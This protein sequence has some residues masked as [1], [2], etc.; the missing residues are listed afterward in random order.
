MFQTSRL[1][2]WGVSMAKKK[3]KSLNDLIVSH[4][5]EQCEGASAHFADMMCHYG[6]EGCIFVKSPSGEQQIYCF[7]DNNSVKNSHEIL[8][9]CA[10]LTQEYMEHNS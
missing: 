6:M 8:K 7:S 9:D 3:N 1:M 4:A 5:Q 2:E 10:K